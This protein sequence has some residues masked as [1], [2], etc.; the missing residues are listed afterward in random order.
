MSR[1]DLPEKSNKMDATTRLSLTLAGLVAIAWTIAVLGLVAITSTSPALAQDQS[2]QQAALQTE[3]SVETDSV[4]IPEDSFLSRET[5]VWNS[6]GGWYS[7][8]A[9]P[10]AALQLEQ[11]VETGPVLNLDLS[12][13]SRVTD[14]WKSSDDWNLD[15]ADQQGA[16]D[17]PA[18][19]QT[20][21]AVEADPAL[22]LD[23]SFL[24]RENDAWQSDAAGLSAARQED[25]ES[26][27]AA[28]EDA[29]RAG[30]WQGGLGSDSDGAFE[31]AVSGFYADQRRKSRQ[32][33]CVQ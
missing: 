3:Q 13:L 31:N 17:Q 4:P 16:A 9:D 1:F 25:L 10:Q 18:T 5:D 32:G 15:A 11:S 6:D 21:Q 7:D 33:N 30:A 28:A 8:A 12:F 27:Y 2:L 26:C 19:V 24:S 29:Y 23:L 14:A 22:N 20:E